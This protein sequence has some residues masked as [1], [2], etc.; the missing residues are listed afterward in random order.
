[1][2]FPT[3][4][5]SG[6]MPGTGLCESKH[7]A[8]LWKSGDCSCSVSPDSAPGR[9]LCGDGGRKGPSARVTRITPEIAAQKLQTQKEKSLPSLAPLPARWQAR[10]YLPGSDEQTSPEHSS[11]RLGTL[12][13]GQVSHF[14]L[15]VYLLMACPVPRRL[16]DAG[17][18]IG[19]SAQLLQCLA[20]FSHCL[21]AAP[22][23]HLQH[24]ELFSLNC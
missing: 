12:V 16:C 9:K 23:G 17:L 18:L 14:V 15:Q 24:L 7:R 13:R 4:L 1:M 11:H 21:P 10:I 2:L 3:V 22:Q 19:D 5:R 20:A 6:Q 8:A